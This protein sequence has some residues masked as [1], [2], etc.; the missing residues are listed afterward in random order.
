MN[1]NLSLISFLVV[2]LACCLFTASLAHSADIKE[3]MAARIPALNALKAEGLI[4]ENSAGYLEYRTAAKPEANLVAD[5]NRDR[6][7]V[8]AAIGKSQGAPADLVGQRRA[9]AIVDIGGKG[10][11]FQ[12]PDGSW[13][14]K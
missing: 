14:Q 5:E 1:K 9:K 13:Y 10:H 3:R 7:A 6:A 11:W 12:R 8:Y 2:A 4:G